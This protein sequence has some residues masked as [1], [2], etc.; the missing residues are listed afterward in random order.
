[1][2][3]DMIFTR[4]ADARSLRVAFQGRWFSFL[5]AARVSTFSRK[6]LLCLHRER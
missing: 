1:M 6:T 3:G 2:R 4:P 5:F